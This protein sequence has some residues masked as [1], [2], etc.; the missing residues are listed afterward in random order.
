MKSIFAA[1]F[2]LVSSSVYAQPCT[3]ADPCINPKAVEATAS[4]DDGATDLNGTQLVT[5]YEAKIML[6]GALVKTIALGRPTLD[7]NRKFQ[8]LLAP[9]RATLSPGVDYTAR[10]SAIGPGGT[11]PASPDSDSFVLRVPVPAASPKPA[12]VR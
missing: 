11:A 9:L 1:A 6:A 2:I 10:L 7:A 4:V 12:I 3:V 8:V 5:G